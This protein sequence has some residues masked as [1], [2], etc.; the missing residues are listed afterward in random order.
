M[1]LAKK[2][3]GIMGATGYVGREAVKTLLAFTDHNIML[4]GREPEKLR[5]IF[6]AMESRGDCL[7]AD[8][9]NRDQLYY[10]CSKCDL[11][12]NCAGPAKQILDRVAAAAIDQG[13]HYV[14]VAGDIHLYKQLR[15]RNQEIAEKKL[16][17]I[18]S[19]G[20]YPG[21]SEVVPAYVAE[22]YFDEIDLLAVF[23]A[24][25]GGFSLNAAY[26]IVCSIEEDTGLG[27][28]Y[29]KNG[30]AQKIEGAFHSSYELPSPAGKVDAYPV[31]NPEFKQIA[32]RYK[33]KSAYFYNTYP[34]KSVLNKFVMIKALAQYKTEEQK[35][36]SAKILV[37]QYAEKK[38]EAGDFTMLH[39]IATGNKNGKYL[40]LVSNLL[41]KNDWNTLSGIVAA[42][43]ARLVAEGNR[44]RAGCFFL[45]E[46]VNAAQL[47]ELLSERNVGLSIHF[48]RGGRG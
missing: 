27:M 33:I 23:F 29:C 14:D 36:A 24:G 37:E 2:T 15:K 11:V 26:D 47:L 41:Y 12:I 5:S 34:N 17:F 16:L 39:L 8:I 10:F 32:A 43:A 7:H 42:N 4:G 30:A 40:E 45:T 44:E 18:V 13:V 1:N 6:P 22:T 9:Y 21:L 38:K 28:T 3:I 31:L 48:S 20:V 46:G 25:Q 19:A 35:K